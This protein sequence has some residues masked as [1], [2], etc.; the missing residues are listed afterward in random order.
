MSDIF[1]LTSDLGT[2][3][4]QLAALKGRLLS[5]DVSLKVV[6]ISHQIN[7]LNIQQAYYILKGSYLYYPEKTI[8]LIALVDLQVS[9]RILLMLFR[10]HYFVAYDD[11]LFDLLLEGESPELM[12]AIEPTQ[13]SELKSPF[14][15]LVKIAL[16]LRSRQSPISIGVP[17][18]IHKIKR[19]SLP[20]PTIID[21]S[22]TIN[23][24]IIYVDHYGNAISNITRSHFLKFE[25]FY[26]CTVQIGMIELKKIYDPYR[27]FNY[28]Q[29]R[30]QEQAGDAFARFNELGFLEIVI[31]KS[32]LSLTGGASTLLG[33]QVKQS[34]QVCFDRK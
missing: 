20:T 33:L 19:A 10:G 25:D 6:D 13:F 24:C 8:H 3:G 14:D 28:F 17:V 11:G 34:I 16:S 31:Y 7:T 26:I 2:K 22:F 32:D 27:D 18:D 9:S 30:H 29:H 23:G 12:I 4:H 5:F 1:T 21:Q 15:R